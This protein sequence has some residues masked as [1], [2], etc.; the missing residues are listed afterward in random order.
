M[1]CKIPNPDAR[2][3][4]VRRIES[5]LLSAAGGALAQRNDTCP[6]GLR[7]YSSNTLAAQQFSSHQRKGGL[8]ASLVAG[9]DNNPGLRNLLLQEPRR[10]FTVATYVAAA[11]PAESGADDVVAKVLSCAAS[12]NTET[13]VLSQVSCDAANPAAVCPPH[14]SPPASASPRLRSLLPPAPTSLQLAE[15]AMGH[16]SDL[17]PEQVRNLCVSFAKLGYF[18]TQFKSVMA[19]AVIEKLGQYDPA[20]LA[21]TAWAFGEALYYD[22]DLM[23]NLHTYLQSNADKFDASGLAKVR[24]PVAHPQDML[25]HVV[26]RTAGFAATAVRLVPPPTRQ[27]QSCSG[28]STRTNLRALLCRRAAC[29]HRTR[30]RQMLWTFGRFGYQ[31]QFL[32]DM[33]H[34][35][36]LK[37]QADCNGKALAD[38]VYA[39]AQLGW[40][41]AR[42]HTL[43]AEYAM[44]N[45][46]V[47]GGGCLGAGGT[48]TTAGVC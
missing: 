15:C 35:I 9:A 3:A 30:Q 1:A 21:D 14:G 6:Q 10:Q 17:T 48:G 41:D 2:T 45:I 18:N 11:A 20:L 34:E 26:V 12:N 37:L 27:G 29:C 33:M 43:V 46:Q 40:A 22:Y 5:L 38:V 13:G 8:L 39:M 24:R 47:G 32:M 25:C 16:A 42:L 31:D 23:T 28:H 36:A 44:D 7:L 19:D 4:S